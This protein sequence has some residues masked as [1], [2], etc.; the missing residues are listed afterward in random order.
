M[1]GAQAKIAE[2][3]LLKEEHNFHPVSVGALV[4]SAATARQACSTKTQKNVEPLR[5]ASVPHVTCHGAYQAMGGSLDPTY[6][7]ANDHTA[8]QS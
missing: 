5:P 1:F 2:E 4:A 3:A 7:R 8:K 6:C